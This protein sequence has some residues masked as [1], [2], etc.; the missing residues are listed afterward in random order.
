MKTHLEKRPRVESV[1]YNTI[2]GELVETKVIL[3][4][5][6]V[7]AIPEQ[8]RMNSKGTEW[9][10]ITVMINHPQ[11][12]LIERTAQLF[13][14]SYELYPEHFQAGSSIELA[15]Q[16]EGEGKGLAKA[17]LVA[18]KRIDIDAWYSLLE[19]NRVEQQ[20]VDEELVA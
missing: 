2:D 13:E 17:Q 15:V 10:L 3:I 12:G 18:A 5:A 4:P 1:V 9:R 8:I 19:E 14:Q 11:L 7:K 16:T 20:V 6:E